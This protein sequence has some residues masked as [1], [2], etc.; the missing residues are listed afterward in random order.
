VVFYFE[1]SRHGS[2]ERYAWNSYGVFLR[3]QKVDLIAVYGVA[4]R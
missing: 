3:A 1:D 2:Q 4:G